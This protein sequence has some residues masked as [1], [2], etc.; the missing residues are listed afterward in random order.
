[1]RARSWRAVAS[2]PVAR[3][4]LALLLFAG[5]LGG[6]AATSWADQYVNSGVAW[7]DDFPPVKQ[8]DVNPLGVNVFLEQEVD[9][10]KV[11]KSLQMVR[12][13]GFKWVRQTFAWNDIEISGKGDYMD[14]R[15]TGPWVD[16]WAKY[17]RIVEGAVSRGLEIIARLDSPPVWARIPGDDV[18]TYHKGPP[19]N[20]GDYAD[21]VRAVATRYK[22]K[23]RY[24]QIWNEP[25]LFGEWG[26]RP[27]SPEEYTQLLKVAY[28]AVKEAN[29][30]AVIITA[31]LAPTAERS[32]ANLNDVLFLEG[33]YRAGAAPYFDVLS[34]ML[35]GL[36][37]PP[38]ERRTD[39]NR[40]SFSRPILLRQVM[41]RNGDAEKPI[42][43]SEYAWLSLP[44][45]FAGD[46]SKN[47][48]GKSVDEGTQGRWL[49]EGY[50]RA[51]SEWPWMG[52][53]AVWHLRF[54]NPQ[55]TEPA[56]YFALLRDDFTPRPA[57]NALREYSKRYPIGD[58]GWYDLGGFLRLGS[59]T[60]LQRR[61][62]DPATIAEGAAWRVATD[63]LRF[64]GNRL[65]TRCSACAADLLALDG[66][67]IGAAPDSST[68]PG[69]LEPEQLLAD[70]LP[71]APH[72]ATV[73]LRY[74]DVQAVQGSNGYVVSRDKPPLNAWGF[75]LVYGIFGLLAVSSAAYGASRLGRWAEAALDRPR[76][77]YAE[78]VREAAR[79]GE[80]VA[81]MAL[82]VMLYYGAN[83]VPPVLAALAGWLALAFVK[84]ATGLA[85]VAFS[86]PFFWY[87]KQIGG[88][89][90]PLAEV[91]LLLVFAAFVAR[92]F[93]EWRLPKLACRLW[94]REGDAIDA[95]RTWVGA[96]PSPWPWPAE[97]RDGKH[98]ATLLRSHA[99]KVKRV[100]KPRGRAA[101][102]VAALAMPMWRRREELEPAH[103]PRKPI[104]GPI[105]ETNL[106]TGV[107]D[108]P[109]ELREQG[110]GTVEESFT[111]QPQKIVRSNRLIP[112]PDPRSLTPILARFR[113]WD[114]QDAFAAPAAAL[115]IVG[116]LSLLTLADPGFARDSA[117][118]LRWTVIEPVLFYF[119][120]TD[121]IGSRRAL[122]RVADFF[123]AAAVGVALLGIWQFVFD[124]GTLEVQGVS[125][126]Q[127]IYQHPNNLALY[128]GRVLPFAL[129]VGIFLPR[130]PRKALYLA[131]SVPLGIATVLTYSRGAWV[132]VAVGVGVAVTL[133]L[134]LRPGREGWNRERLREMWLPLVSGAAL[135]LGLLLI[136]TAALLP[137][138]PERIFTLGSGNM[139]LLL[140][141]SSL[142]MLSDHPV[143]GVGPDQF[144]NQ[145]Q[146][147][148]MR[149]EQAGESYTSHPHNIILDY[150]LSL[151][152]MGL[153]I[154]VWLLW[155]YFREA[156]GIV[157]RFASEA[158][159]DL[160]ST[161][162][163]LGLI[164]SMLDFL[165]HGMVDNSYF[166]MDL[167]LVF[168]LSCGLLNVMRRLVTSN[169]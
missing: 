113:E 37:Q 64:E 91:L 1:M 55:P 106:D 45:D 96:W 61:E 101:P 62:Y 80:L 146:A 157:R 69:R 112:T 102:R 167:A 25:N 125:R 155:K 138:V 124:A 17:D 75:P 47:I 115:L 153:L 77:R 159:G 99:V 5:S 98:K 26:G 7:G 23:V 166:L 67:Q 132:G 140:W 53:M 118:A 58:T 11:E 4:F 127:G 16:A 165:V 59:Q 85:A 12:D 111:N 3:A 163:A 48:W 89:K 13:G 51:E 117:R 143:F 81:G 123:V 151:G 66:R 154:L 14:R 161:A 30:E 74:S 136:A 120:L 128:L 56:N 38:Q 31:A 93:V 41:E 57:Y 86:I 65:G 27:V 107:L 95:P 6:L 10:A 145:F 68:P 137:R 139:R 131:G 116:T 135:V 100:P 28:Q 83:S 152:I 78:R 79:N 82:L 144:L 141:D 126:V 160:A 8:S 149:P 29:P 2:N 129:C 24:F 42:W 50:E 119:L 104:T 76:G 84:P 147:R 22:G 54:A 40:L 87:P 73:R 105:G 36:G 34:T 19:N 49:V 121:L 114:R 168:W 94:G 97:L 32:L 130:G 18:Q 158:G 169:A 21:F 63:T 44:D 164:A 35:Y 162:L 9:P 70:S 90:F 72:T 15:G 110:N 88:Q 20:Y 122:W 133:G 150:W 43:I 33:M 46:P 108:V 52:V 39:L 134:L 71:Y 109:H 60:L 103:W 142:R 156:V 92:R 148:Y